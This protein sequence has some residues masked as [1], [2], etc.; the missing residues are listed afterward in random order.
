[1]VL[2][3]RLCVF[4]L[5]TTK[6][7]YSLK[8]GC[9]CMSDYAISWNVFGWCRI[10][11]TAADLFFHLPLSGMLISAAV[12]HRGL[13]NLG[14]GKEENK[15]CFWSLYKWKQNKQKAKE[16]N[17]PG[18]QFVYAK[19]GIHSERF[20]QFLALSLFKCFSAVNILFMILHVT[21]TPQDH[22][23]RRRGSC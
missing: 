5:V 4:W 16:Q 2:P 11:L 21:D 19:A 1:M 3:E 6:V 12:V 14:K 13:D 22:I 23:G 7:S 15:G 8:Q 18:K 17:R 10:L 9:G 20:F